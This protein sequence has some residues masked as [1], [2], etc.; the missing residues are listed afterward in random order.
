M[1]NKKENAIID[2]G[3][4]QFNQLKTHQPVGLGGGESRRST[5]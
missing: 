5:T 3:T 2:D 1:E 4:L